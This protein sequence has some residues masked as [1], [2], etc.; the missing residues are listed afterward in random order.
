MAVINSPS[1]PA[2]LTAPSKRGPRHFNL[3]Y[4]HQFVFPA[5]QTQSCGS[6]DSVDAVAAFDPFDQ[7][8]FVG[9]VA[10]VDQIYT[11]LIDGD[12]IQR[13]QNTDITNAGIFGDGTAVARCGVL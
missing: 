3:L 1:Q 7:V 13:H 5:A 9:V 6:F 4:F 12:G 8:R 11:S 10:G 2:R